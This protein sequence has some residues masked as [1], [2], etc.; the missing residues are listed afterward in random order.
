MS[1]GPLPRQ[2]DIRKLTSSGALLEGAVKVSELG[3]L[4]QALVGDSG[5]VAY[6]L[7]FGVTEEGIPCICGRVSTTVQVK[8]E[9]CLEPMELAIASE[10]SLGVVHGD[11]QARQLPARLEPLVVE[12]DTVDTAAVVEDEVLLCL[13][14][15]S[16]HSQDECK[17]QAGYQSSPE[18]RQP[19]AEERKNP[20]DV[21]A[22]LKK[23][24]S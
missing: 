5:V 14:I 11:D 19:A 6:E 20:F 10:F 4:A 9:R 12:L 3:R 17:Q 22:A 18:G 21:L 7:R 2:A 23:P 24:E 15:V 13:P 8:C 1:T 16:Y